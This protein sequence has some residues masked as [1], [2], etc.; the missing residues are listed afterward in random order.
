MKIENV[1]VYG[2]PE[3]IIASGYPMRVDCP[4]GNDFDIEARLISEELY[5]MR[6]DV[7][8]N[9][10]LTE[11]E[12]NPHIKRA[13]N[14]GSAKPN[15]GHDSMLKGIIVQYDLTCNHIMLPQFMR[16]HFHDIISSQS[17]MHRI[18][19]MD[20]TQSC[21]YRVRKDIIEACKEEIEIYKN[22]VEHKDEFTKEE[23]AEQYEVVMENLPM[24][25][26]LTMRVTSS[27]LQ[28]KTIRGQRNGHK[29]GFWREYCEWQDTLPYF[30]QL[31]GIE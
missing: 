11:F 28:E 19:Q 6:F 1:R 24:G 2:I 4:F 27:Y 26:N 15:S 3:S 16:Y 30:K 5:G 18:T 9:L 14:L 10:S 12:D 22:M 21:G 20:L 23:M 13:F 8:N 25:L 29:M 17:K 31:I 7:C